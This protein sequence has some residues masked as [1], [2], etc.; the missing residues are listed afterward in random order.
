MARD[1]N[2]I[3]HRPLGHVSCRWLLSCYMNE[4]LVDMERVDGLVHQRHC[5]FTLGRN[6]RTAD[7]ENMSLV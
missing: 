3:H 2:F 6:G 4:K 1:G 7:G 5:F